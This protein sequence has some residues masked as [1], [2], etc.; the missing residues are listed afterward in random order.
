MGLCEIIHGC[1]CCGCF[2]ASGGRF[3]PHE[4]ATEQARSALDTL[5]AKK[6]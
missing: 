3:R 5:F 4:A 1:H 6:P 2:L